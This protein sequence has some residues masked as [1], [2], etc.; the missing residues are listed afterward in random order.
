LGV[1]ASFSMKSPGNIF[2]EKWTLIHALNGKESPYSCPN[3]IVYRLSAPK[4]DHY[5]F[6]NDNEPRTTSINFLNYRYKSFI[7]AV[8]GELVDP[9]A[10][11][12]EGYS[13]RWIRCEKEGIL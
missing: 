1:D 3:A 8:T 9:S 10:I 11:Q 13:G 6:I 7:D 2:M 12:L 4:A 5:F